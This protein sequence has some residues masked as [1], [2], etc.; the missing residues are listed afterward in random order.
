MKKVRKKKQIKKKT[1]FGTV[2]SLTSG[3]AGSDVTKIIIG[4]NSVAGNANV[5]NPQRQ[6]NNITAFLSRIRGNLVN[7]SQTEFAK[8]YFDFLGASE[9]L[10]AFTYK[11]AWNESVKLPKQFLRLHLHRRLRYLFHHFLL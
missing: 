10:K 2:S 8:A 6:Q 1:K 4:Q 3:T 11:Y 9:D 7:I 5:K